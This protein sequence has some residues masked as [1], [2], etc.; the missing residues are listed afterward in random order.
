[1]RK[2]ST[3]AKEVVGNKRLLVNEQNNVHEFCWYFYSYCSR[4]Y[5]G[6]LPTDAATPDQEG[7]V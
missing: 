1:M 6:H 7:K 3:I 5:E 4:V 2:N